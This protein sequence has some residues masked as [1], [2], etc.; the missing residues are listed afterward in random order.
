M[1]EMKWKKKVNKITPSSSA[2]AQG[3]V[4][5]VLHPDLSCKSGEKMTSLILRPNPP[6]VWFLVSSHYTHQNWI[7]FCVYYGATVCALLLFYCLWGKLRLSSIQVGEW[8]LQQRGWKCVHYEDMGSGLLKEKSI[9]AS[10][11]WPPE[12]V[13]RYE[14]NCV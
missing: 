14:I 5:L 4:F 11:T 1:E 3:Q 9:S 8:N 10:Q 12:S 13:D 7:F 2:G 6:Q